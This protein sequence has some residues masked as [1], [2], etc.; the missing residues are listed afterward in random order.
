[1]TE[2]EGLDTRRL[3]FSQAQGYEGL[4]QP[5][6]L[7]EISYE[8]RV[9][10]WDLLLSSACVY[11]YAWQWKQDAPWPQIFQKLHIDFL[12][13]P[14]DEFEGGGPLRGLNKLVETYK[15]LVLSKL[16]FNKIFDLF[17]MIM[18]HPECPREFTLGVAGVFKECR[19]AYVVDTKGTPTILP[20]AT[21]AE[22]E[23]IVGAI[24]ELREVRL[25]GAEAQ[26]KKAGELINSGDWP[27]SV[28]ESIHAVE[29][30]ARR[31]DPDASKT[32]GP[33]LKS[34]EKRGQLHPALK[35]AFS[36][37]YGYTSD[38]EGIRHALLTDAASPAGRDEAVFMLGACASFASYLWRRGQQGASNSK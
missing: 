8:A 21:R 13:Q 28:R 16:P 34:L 1:M 10:L 15:D 18:R 17:Q 26:L 35:E 36:N 5:L 20:A 31:L 22:G 19:L 11:V 38:E 25:H 7:G 9:R 23:A 30:V 6:A 24:Q 14:P 2:H 29:S 32:L 33:A 3:T 37:L 27:G 12:V 4:P